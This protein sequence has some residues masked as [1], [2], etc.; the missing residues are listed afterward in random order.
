[1]PSEITGF[2]YKDING[3]QVEGD[4]RV[5]NRFRSA[6]GRTTL[7]GGALVV[8]YD[9]GRIDDIYFCID[10][11]EVVDGKKAQTQEEGR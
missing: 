1:M 11:L 5:Y 7:W 9:D 4:Q 6:Y 2:G 3:V 10:S 8:K